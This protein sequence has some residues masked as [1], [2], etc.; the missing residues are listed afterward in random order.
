[1]ERRD[2]SVGIP[3]QKYVQMRWSLNGNSLQGQALATWICYLAY[4][5]ILPLNDF[6]CAKCFESLGQ[7]IV[8]LIYNAH[9]LVSFLDQTHTDI[10]WDS[11]IISL[12]PKQLWY[13]GFIAWFVDLDNAALLCDSRLGLELVEEEHWEDDK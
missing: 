4:A 2:I 5:I 11:S 13:I 6:I 7:S 12:Q 1:M 10:L 3:A 8:G 9:S